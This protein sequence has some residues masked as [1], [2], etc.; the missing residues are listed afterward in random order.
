MRHNSRAL[1]FLASVCIAAFFLRFTAPSLHLYFSPDDSMNL[2]R[3]WKFPLTWL[4]KANLLFFLNSPFYRPFVSVWYRSIYYFAG[5][6]PAPFH[7]VILI[8]VAANLW[9]TYAVSRRL[10]DSREVGVLAALLVS[11]QPSFGL[12]YFD[13]GFAYDVI[14]YFFYFSAFLFYLRVRQQAHPPRLWQ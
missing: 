12:L 7:A 14:C 13:T 9:L 1:P 8:V 11:Y 10:T 4:V 5:F 2:Y 6:N 3:S